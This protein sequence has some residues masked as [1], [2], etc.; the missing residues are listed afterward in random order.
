MNLKPGL[1][2]VAVALDTPDWDEFVE[3]CEFFGPR[4]G[5]LKVG[6]EAYTRWGPGAVIEARRHGAGVFLDLKLH[7]IPHTVAGA[8]AAV[9]DQG[10]DYLTV[11]AAGGPA[12]LAAAAAAAQDRVRLL[13]VTLLTHLDRSALSALDLPGEAPAR[14]ERWANLAWQ[15][16]CHGAVCSP[17]EVKALR[18]AL[19]AP[20]VLVTPGIRLGESVADDDQA[21][22]A[23]PRTALGA[24]SDV[25]VVGRPLTRAP[26]RRTALARWADRISGAGTA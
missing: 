11:H 19:S 8:V 10:V 2:C 6:L 23:D 21:R 26:D 22:V 20:F 5:L 3:L 12:M 14:A 7:D 18:A 4:V 13:A 9:C 17:H 25:L 16:G 15:A 1:E 24:G